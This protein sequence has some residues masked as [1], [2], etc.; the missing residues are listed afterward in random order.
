MAALRHPCA[1]RSDG[2]LQPAVLEWV[3]TTAARPRCRPRSGPSP[4][5]D[6]TPTDA[7]CDGARR[8]P[9]PSRARG[10]AIEPLTRGLSAQ[11]IRRQAVEI[12]APAPLALDT[13]LIKIAPGVDP[14]VVK[15]VEGDA[16]RVVAD[17]LDP[18][19]PDMGAPGYQRLL[20]RTVP[21]HF[22]RR[23]LDPQ[24][25]GRKTKLAAVVKGDIEELFRLLQAELYRPVRCLARAQGH[26][27]KLPQGDGRRLVVVS[28]SRNERA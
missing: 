11:P 23:A 20:P 18:D 12:V 27:F 13:E 16:N 7:R 17:R 2:G 8:R 6:K 25:L 28:S 15:I 4:A 9:A 10:A 21:L 5:A 24:I 1:G 14:G 26:S 22:S 19:D 3:P